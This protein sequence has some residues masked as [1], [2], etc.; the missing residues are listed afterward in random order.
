[1]EL[2]EGVDLRRLASRGE[3][4]GEPMPVALAGYVI[5]Q[6]LWALEAAHAIVDEEGRG[7]P[8]VHRDIS[9][10]NVLI[11]RYGEVRVTDFGLAKQL[12]EAD[13]LT[14]AGEIRGKYCYMPPEQLEARDV[15][16]RTDLFAVGVTFYELL[17][18]RRPYEAANPLEAF[19]RCQ[20]PVPHPRDLRPDLNLSLAELAFRWRH[21]EPDQR[22]HDVAS[23]R[24][25]L[26]AVLELIVTG[27]PNVQLAE[28]VERITSSEAAG[29]Q[30]TASGSKG[31][32]RPCAKCGGKLHAHVG[33]DGVIAD[34][35][36]DCRGVWLDAH[37]LRRI[38]GNTPRVETVSA[39]ALGGQGPASLDGVQ[40]DCPRCRV[41][42]QAIHVQGPA[43]E[44][45]VEQ[46]GT[47]QGIWFDQDELAHFVAGGLG[48]AVRAAGTL[49]F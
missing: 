1:M 13:Q 15:D 22:G 5:H 4:L 45:H 27:M 10:E 19:E 38:L 11:G 48:M 8:M 43:F 32:R 36:P 20:Q 29:V 31:S 12:V 41:T 9:P 14:R 40:G 33:D 49:T 47:C 37:E 46:C 18:G 34:T 24:R 35:C 26:S 2:V 30:H 7:A 25:E 17:C 42:L 23:A 39:L 6:V 21:P 44:F 3:I 16:G 28:W